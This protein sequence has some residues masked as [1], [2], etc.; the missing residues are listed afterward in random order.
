MKILSK[1]II[2]LSLAFLFLFFAG[3]I[4]FADTVLA[5]QNDEAKYNI[6]IQYSPYQN[7]NPEIQYDLSYLT[8]R[9]I[10]HVLE[11]V[12]AIDIDWL[13]VAKSE[14]DKAKELFK[15]LKNMI[16]KTTVQVDIKHGDGK[17]VYSDSRQITEREI[18][19][20]AGL[21][22][23]KVVKPAIRYQKRKGRYRSREVSEKTVE[24]T[25]LLV[26]LDFVGQRVDSVDALFSADKIDEGSMKLQ[27]A[28]LYGI[29]V[30]YLEVPP[31]LARAFDLFV[32]AA[33]QAEQKQKREANSNVK[34]AQASLNR[35]ASRIKDQKEKE[36]ILQLAKDLS[37]AVSTV[38][39]DMPRKKRV[40]HR[41]LQKLNNG[42]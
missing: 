11:A 27:E 32:L 29:R 4:Y 16:P 13:Q 14:I 25:Y 5:G 40:W 33:R 28:L 30:D 10:Y 9:M 2:S 31:E 42:N 15:I 36:D 22:S 6:S 24:L 26:D 18:P 1:N 7:I 38:A 20:L 34:K 37:A 8:S 23:F 39:P 17:T 3:G 19:V 35:Y 21:T 12:R 41:F